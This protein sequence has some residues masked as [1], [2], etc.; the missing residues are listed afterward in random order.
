M[1]RKILYLC[2]L[3]ILLILLFAWL[4]PAE[5]D[6]RPSFSPERK[7]PFASRILYQEL[8]TIRNEQIRI[9]T[10]P[11]YNVIH[12]LDPDTTYCYF[13]LNANLQTAELDLSELL[14]FASDGQTVF[15]A[16]E[17]FPDE[18]L[19]TLHLAQQFSYPGGYNLTDWFYED[20][21]TLSLQSHRDETWPATTR[22]GYQWFESVDSSE[23]DTLGVV[24]TLY[25][26]FIACPFGEGTIFLHAFPYVFTNYHMLY[27]ENH[28]YV[29]AAMAEIPESEVWLWDKYYVEDYLTSAQTP[30]A[31]LNQ[32]RSFRWA[33]WTG[34][35]LLVIFILFTAKRKQRVIPLV[36]PK[37]NR[38]LDYV[39]TI[40]DLYFHRADHQ[41]LVKKKIEILRHQLEK[42][43]RLEVQS[44][45]PE[46]AD[47]V[48]ARSGADQEIVRKLF[49]RIRSFDE[50]AQIRA[51]DLQA[52]QQHLH[53]F[54]QSEMRKSSDAY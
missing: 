35:I 23:F 41:D 7:I 26:N 4:R 14:G 43:Y 24:D 36:K 13:L 42:K 52:F 29:S 32:Y 31:A 1:T 53:R 20:N 8:P 15:I 9:T 12:T 17:Y 33:Y 28:H 37:R 18:L 50:L 54:S 40:G 34:M 3:Y 49:H 21:I 6:W 2:V 51:V 46:D 22:S 25:P 10:R 45:M 44:F 38:T 11:A 47:A 16:S 27:K 5:I 30:L 48:A 39:R 19:D